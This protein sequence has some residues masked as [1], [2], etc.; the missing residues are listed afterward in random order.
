MKLMTGGNRRIFEH[1]KV[2]QRAHACQILSDLY[3]SVGKDRAP[4]QQILQGFFELKSSLNI[5]LCYALCA[6][7]RSVLQSFSAELIIFREGESLCTK[8]SCCQP[9]FKV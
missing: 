2:F 8:Y 6:M 5:S 7:Q 1:L 4:D 9:H 3:S